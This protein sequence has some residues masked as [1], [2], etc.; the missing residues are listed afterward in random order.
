[1]WNLAWK[2]L[3]GPAHC[4]SSPAHSLPSPALHWMPNEIHWGPWP[5][6][7]LFIF[8]CIP[9]KCTNS[10]KQSWNVTAWVS[11]SGQTHPKLHSQS[12][13]S[14]GWHRAQRLRMLL[15]MPNVSHIHVAGLGSRLHSGV[16]PPAN[17]HPGMI[18]NENLY[19]SMYTAA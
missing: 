3:L 2:A 18:Y 1:M 8:C 9:D 5:Y 14:R 12:P 7:S 15:R 19:T 11:A 10:S 17:V 16:Q 6:L 13:H 4:P